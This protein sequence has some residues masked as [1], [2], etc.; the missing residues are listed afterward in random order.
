MRNPARGEPA[1]KAGRRWSRVGEPD[2]HDTTRTMSAP[3]IAGLDVSKNHLDVATSDGRAFRVANTPAGH[4]TLVTRLTRRASGCRVVLEATGTYSLEVA[5]A[6]DAADRC[7]VMVANPRLVKGFAVAVAQRSKTDR[8]DAK[9]I[10]A[11]AE[12]MPFEPWTPPPAHLVELRAL[13]RRIDDLTVETTREKNRLSSLRASASHSQAVARDIEVNL[14]HLE[15]RTDRMVAHA[16]ALVGAHADL[17]AAFSH[18]TSMKGFADK[19]GVC[20]LAELLVLPAD[21]TA[22]QW[23]AHAGLDPRE[24]TSG[25]SVHRPV[26][27][28]KVGNAHIRRVLF[29]PAMVA[30]VREPRVKAYYDELIGRGK[31]P[32]AAYVA[33]MRKLLHAVHGMLKHRSDFDGERFRATPAKAVVEA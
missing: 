16:V 13:T 6:L 31:A 8:A 29:M 33:V 19:S 27:I 22:K 14:R 11:F 7:A 28:S 12:R 5:L 15:R 23:V 21:M 2:S 24:H 4:Q 10:L 26:R 25:S 1:Y 3:L 18:V 17:S 20:L 30:C 9:T 32:Y